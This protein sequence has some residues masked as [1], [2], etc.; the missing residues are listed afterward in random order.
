MCDLLSNHDFF[1]V[2]PLYKV[3][4]KNKK[5]GEYFS[6]ATGVKYPN[7]AYFSP[8]PVVRKQTRIGSYFRDDLFES[9]FKPDMV[10]RTAGFVKLEDAQTL[11]EAIAEELA[12]DVRKKQDDMSCPPYIEYGKYAKIG[13]NL[14]TYEVVIVKIALRNSVFEGFYDG[15][16]VFAGKEM[17]ITE[18]VNEQA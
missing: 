16:K 10:G 17:C 1:H 14:D 7:E 3:V 11:M 4:L 13:E 2:D 15:A 6:P 8:V 5:T 18:E 9:F 12:Q